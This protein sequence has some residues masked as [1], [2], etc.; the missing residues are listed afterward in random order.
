[1]GGGTC[2]SSIGERRMRKVAGQKAHAVWRKEETPEGECSKEEVQSTR[3]VRERKGKR[4]L[5]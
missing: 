5:T 1:M 4:I 2:K 3:D